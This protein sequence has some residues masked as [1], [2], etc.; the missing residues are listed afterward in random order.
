MSVKSIL[1]THLANRSKVDHLKKENDR[2]RLQLHK[3][4]TLIKDKF[5]EKMYKR[6][7][8]P[9]RFAEL[10]TQLASSR[11]Y[12]RTLQEQRRVLREE[13]KFLRQELRKTSLPKL[14]KGHKEALT[15]SLKKE[16]D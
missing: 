3:A 10:Q 8:E 14:P 16:G 11:K 13:N 9:A 1:I 6:I 4:E 15:N 2:L 5:L 7:D 12:V